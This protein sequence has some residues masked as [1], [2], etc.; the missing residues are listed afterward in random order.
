MLS[1]TPYKQKLRRAF[2]LLE[3]LT[4]VSL[5]GIIATVVL[6]RLTTHSKGARINACHVHRGNIE[7]Q[8]EL[9]FRNRGKWPAA[10]LSDIGTTSRYFPDGLVKCP[11]DDSRYTLNPDTGRVIGHSHDR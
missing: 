6:P 7:V 5:M 11:V 3:V 9:W 2:S 1:Q 10:S 8:T 4:V